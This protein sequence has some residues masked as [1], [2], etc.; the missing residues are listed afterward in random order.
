MLAAREK[1]L[2]ILPVEFVRILIAVRRMVAVVIMAVMMGNVS[3][4]DIQRM[5][6][7]FER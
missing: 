4:I 2:A 6:T 3:R 1:P 7:Q 5:D